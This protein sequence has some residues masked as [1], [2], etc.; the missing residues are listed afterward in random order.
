MKKKNLD[1]PNYCKPNALAEVF[2]SSLQ[3]AKVLVHNRTCE[4]RNL[5]NQYKNMAEELK[6]KWRFT[7]ENIQQQ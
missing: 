7:L 2:E 1:D 5:Y 3:D 4:I 6:M